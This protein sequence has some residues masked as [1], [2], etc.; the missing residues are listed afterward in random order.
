MQ[1]HSGE[2]MSATDNEVSTGVLAKNGQ[3]VAH[4]RAG[5]EAERR[6]HEE[7]SPRDSGKTT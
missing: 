4:E 5:L 2:E 6:S 7:A 3:S 1:R